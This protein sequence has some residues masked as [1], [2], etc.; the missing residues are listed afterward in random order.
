MGTHGRSGHEH[1]E[2]CMVPLLKGYGGGTNRPGSVSRRAL[3]T[4]GANSRKKV[5]HAWPYIGSA[6]AERSSSCS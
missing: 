1:G 4:G 6:S 3:S 2:E 5:N